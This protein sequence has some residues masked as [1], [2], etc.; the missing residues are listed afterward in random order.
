MMVEVRKS[1]DDL[2]EDHGAHDAGGNSAQ[3]SGVLML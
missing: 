2:W 3:E 1:T